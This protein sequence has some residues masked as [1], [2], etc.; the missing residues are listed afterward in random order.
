VISRP[1][2]G[3]LCSYGYVLM[4]IYFLTNVVQPPVLPNLQ[5]LPRSGV[6][7]IEDIECEG[8]N[9]SFSDG[10]GWKSENTQV[11]LPKLS[12]LSG[13]TL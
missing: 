1:R 6:V 5:C 7:R 4:V 3:T 2:Y 13:L 12:Y 10:N 9:I 11:P 8:C